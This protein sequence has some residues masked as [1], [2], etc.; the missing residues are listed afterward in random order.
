[1]ETSDREVPEVL[2]LANYQHFA[3][4]CISNNG[5]S[6]VGN[7]CEI[8][9]PIVMVLFV[10]PGCTLLFAAHI[11]PIIYRFREEPHVT[12]MLCARHVYNGTIAELCA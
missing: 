10:V 7:S 11:Y 2:V 1:V 4:M 5:S 12:D 6:I 3:C 9:K 8:R